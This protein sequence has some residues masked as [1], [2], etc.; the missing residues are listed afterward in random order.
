MHPERLLDR[1][2][3]ADASSSSYHHHSSLAAAGAAAADTNNNTL[4]DFLLRPGILVPLGI[5]LLSALYQSLVLHSSSA[6]ASS[7]ASSAAGSGGPSSLVH[8]HARHNNNKKHKHKY[9]PGALLWDLF[10]TL[11]PGRLLCALDRWLHPS[12]PLFPVPD[13]D[14]MSPDADSDSN[15]HSNI[16]SPRAPPADL[17]SMPL[18]PNSVSLVDQWS[19]ASP[20]PYP[21][22]QRPL[23]PPPLLP[24]DHSM[25][26]PEPWSHEVKSE[27]LCRLLGMEREGMGIM[28]A[29]AHA[30]RRMR[31][32]GR[33][34]QVRGGN[35]WRQT[36]NRPPGLG[37]HDNSCFQNSVLQSLSSLKTFPA[38]LTSALEAV[39]ASARADDCSYSNTK[40]RYNKRGRASFDSGGSEDDPRSASGS[41]VATL[42]DLLSQLTDAESSGVTL[43]TPKKLKSL[44]TWQQQDAQEYY[45]TILD[46]IDKE[47]TRAT[48]VAHRRSS[49][50]LEAAA[51]V[52]SIARDDDT[53]ASQHS[54]DSGYQ[55][56]ST[57][58]ALGKS[59]SSSSPP[60]SSS[61]SG[62]K[63]ATVI[64]N[65]LEGLVAQRVACVQCGH[66]Q[67]LSMIPFNCI[68]LSLGVDRGAHDLYERL[69]AYTALEPIQ[70]VECAKCTLLE[71]RRLGAI[72][73][74]RHRRDGAAATDDEV[75]REQL[76]RF[77]AVEEA[78]ED[79]DF[80][81]AT[82]RDKCKIARQHRIS[83]T[84]TKQMVIGRPPT[85]LA[86][87]VNRSMF[88][89]RT[90]R[91][92]KNPAAVR[93]PRT[94]DLG[95]WCLGSA[96]SHHA[97][98]TS[99]RTSVEMEQWSSDPES[100]MVSGDL[101]P[102]TMS[103][104]IYE[105]RAVITHQGR[106]ENGHYVCYR[107]H[108]RRPVTS[109]GSSNDEKD[110]LHTDLHSHYHHQGSDTESTDSS[111][112][113]KWWRLSDETVWQVDEKTVLDQGDVFML[114]YDCVDPNPVL[115]SDDL[116]QDRMNL[117][118]DKSAG[119]SEAHEDERQA[120]RSE[121]GALERPEA[122]PHAP[123]L[124]LTTA[125]GCE[126]L[127]AD[128]AVN[129]VADYTTSLL[130]PPLR[131][132]EHVDPMI[133]QNWP[134]K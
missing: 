28:G 99:T 125:L 74:A 111:D 73:L 12:S 18:D 108:P 71:A 10:V 107:K 48:A 85:S 15:T 54:D 42:R 81:E 114:F 79:D 106:H 133:P 56:L 89:E 59:S 27:M 11:I 118:E 26:Q 115:V 2:H 6:S 123:H 110:V 16:M 92:S 120:A 4:W 93:F 78:L 52:S 14:F 132:D 47:V 31:I 5:L 21:P 63:T 128:C 45:S 131:H 91:M 127:P 129:R 29:M 69:D 84:K 94:L 117:D 32:S 13:S 82:L 34:R 41:S 101:Q 65:P 116:D 3:F 24:P 124:E 53:V 76:A 126:E 67:G 39:R 23:P 17:N 134:M 113:S 40:N 77:K 37:N 61:L 64:R 7:S 102:S 30:G 90:G 35:K 72:V 112:D 50:G 109:E 95:P 55:S 46:E 66:S 130:H 22:P 86:V 104:P 44:D 20:P 96:G 1:S 25:S 36:V 97:A 121:L 88:D 19:S 38:F 80:E 33:A 62:A 87:H 98:Q 9:H 70:G 49:P 8:A 83:S 105:L 68:T 103:G 122:I 75:L 57:T 43:W 100:S 119:L 60:I 51:F 58:T